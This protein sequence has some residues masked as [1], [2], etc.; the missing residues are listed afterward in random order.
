MARIPLIQE[1]E[2]PD[3]AGVIERVK[4]GRRGSLLNVY[5]I[6]LHSPNIAEAWMGLVD[7]IRTASVLDARTK[8]IAIIRCAH[9]ND[10]QYEMKQHVPRLAAAAG[11]DRTECEAI[12][13]WPEG[14]GLSEADQAVI[15]YADAVTRHVHVADAVFERLRPHF[16][17]REIVELSIVVGVYNMHARVIEPLEID[18]EPGH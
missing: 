12:R 10:S 7:A 18:P 15:A 1:G 9:V 2:S 3:L 13:T 16:S 5:R 17:T 8:E 4:A 11:L 6:L 14:D